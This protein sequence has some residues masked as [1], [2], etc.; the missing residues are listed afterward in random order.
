MPSSKSNSQSAGRIARAKNG[1]IY[2]LVL[3][4]VLTGV[5]AGVAALANV[6]LYGAFKASDAAIEEDK[7]GAQRALIFPDATSFE[8]VKAPDIEG[9][10]SVWKSDVGDFVFDVQSAGYHGDVEL[11]IGIT[12]DGKVAGIQ[13]VA[14]DE[15]EGIGTNALTDEYLASFKDMEATGT[16]T[17]KE[18]GSGET[19]VDG[20]SGATFTSTAVVGDLNIAFEAFAEV[21]GN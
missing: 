4:L 21:G 16:L 6:G 9:L 12:A 11:M 10:N 14:E 15:T 1:A 2:T 19:H 20:V 17:V 8:Q 18:A 3:L 5:G 7:G 13:I